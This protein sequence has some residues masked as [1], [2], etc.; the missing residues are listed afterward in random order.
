MRRFS[1]TALFAML[2][3]LG[4][5]A[6]AQCGL[7]IVAS[8]LNLT[9]DLNWS[10]LAISI[11]VNKA[12]AAACSYGLGFTKGGAASYT[13][14]ATTGSANLLY[15]VYSDSSKT[16]ILK[17]VPDIATVNDV[18]MSGFPAG[19]NLSQTI[20]YYFDIPYGAATSPTLTP[21]GTFTD[22]FIINAYDGADPLTFVTPAAS[23]N[24]N[25]S[26]SV[27][28]IIALSLVDTGGVFQT[29]A[30]TKNLDFGNVYPDMMSRFDLRIR[31]N[32]GYSITFSSANDGRMKHVTASSY[33]PYNFKVNGA[34][35]NMSASS[36]TP[37]VGLTGSGQTPIAGL[38]FP[39][40]FQI[41]TYGAL[42]LSG[43]HSDT[44]LITATSTE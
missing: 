23:A 10:T 24:I 16:K 22:S 9:W 13:R 27:P 42:A 28:T 12:N 20:I 32:S 17:D 38:G 39:I 3:F 1:Q 31:S 11:T 44:V 2:L 30:T 4:F 43:I 29:A 7:S 19:N 36:G 35:L 41:G 18:I 26:I 8:D 37:V 21:S 34:L 40:Q 14:A 15:Q 25:V 5:G 6:K 33:V